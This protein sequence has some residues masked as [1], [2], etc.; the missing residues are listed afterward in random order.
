[1]PFAPRVRQRFHTHA[2]LVPHRV[3]TFAPVIRFTAAPAT[4][5]VTQRWQ[6]E[7]CVQEG[8]DLRCPGTRNPVVGFHRLDVGRIVLTAADVFQP[9]WFPSHCL[10]EVLADRVRSGQAFS[11]T[12]CFPLRQ[13][14]CWMLGSW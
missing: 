4:A 3:R 8:F 9:L 2:N 10:Q 5:D 11:T 12:A 13:R 6:A 14:L 1:M 7:R